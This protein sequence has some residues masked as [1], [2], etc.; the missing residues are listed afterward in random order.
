[1]FDSGAIL[2]SEVVKT[3][4]FSVYVHPK[5]AYINKGYLLIKHFLTPSEVDAIGDELERVKK[6]CLKNK[7]LKAPPFRALGDEQVLKALRDS[8]FGADV[9]GTPGNVDTVGH[10]LHYLQDST[11][12]RFIH[13]TRL[14]EV[15]DSLTDI[16]EPVVVQTKAVLKPA[17]T[18]TRVPAHTDEQYI[19]TSPQT[20]LALWIALD[21][22]TRVNGCVEVVEGSHVA[23]QSGQQFADDGSG[24]ITWQQSISS[25]EGLRPFPYSK[26]ELEELAWIP[27]EAASGDCL[28]MHPRLL[29]SS[30][31]NT[32]AIPR[33]AL[34]LHLVDG[35]AKWDKRN[36]IIPH[37]QLG[38]SEGKVRI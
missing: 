14:K 37:P 16:P 9:F 21:D 30:A 22:A 13:S 32:S 18:G 19:F 15:L 27:V 17:K 7:G 36:W 33:R 29:H 3:K 25:G 4:R 38:F 34:T 35:T 23:F 10:G 6:V 12:E 20:G 24:K 28:I 8:C 2:E 11:F 31:P 1:M 26:K 5:E